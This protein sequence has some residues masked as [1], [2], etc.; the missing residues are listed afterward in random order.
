MKMQ[1]RAGTAFLT[2][3][4]KS[5]KSALTKLNTGNKHRA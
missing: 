3:I 1:Y 2:D 4:Y 5:F